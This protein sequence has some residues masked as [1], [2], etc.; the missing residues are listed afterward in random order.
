MTSSKPRLWII[1][2][3]FP[4]DESSTSYILGE[5]AKKMMSKYDVNVICGPEIY[6][7][8]M[9]LSGK[10][11]PGNIKINRIK[12]LNLDKN[13]VVGK[14]ISFILITYRLHR[15]AKSKI[16]RSDKVLMVTNPATL[17]VPIS[18]LKKKAGFSL[19]IL[20]HDVFPENAKAAGITFPSILYRNLKK[21]FDK[22]YSRADR[23]IVLGRDMEEVVRAKTERY[24]PNISISIIENWGDVD[25]ITPVAFPT[26]PIKLQYAGNIGRVQGLS[27]VIYQLP[28]NIEFHIYGTGA[29]ENK[30]KEINAKNV[31][32]HGAYKRCEQT[33]ILGKC[34]IALVTLNDGMYGLGVPSKTYNILASGRPILFLGPKNSE[35][36]RLVKEKGVGFCE[37]PEKWDREVLKQM[38]AK[39]RRIAEKEYSKDIILQKFSQL[40]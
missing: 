31:Y 28:N 33:E 30:L 1:S 19:D 36:Y 12:G 5:I 18:R 40:I 15:M 23:L 25:D 10:S 27:N 29:I 16:N 7:K 26:G 14:I 8:K 4:P 37:W 17:I 34:D 2:E 3:L 6:D 32:F 22:A 35:V 21:I 20:V 9:I 24:S 11:L 39:A 38:G 13:T